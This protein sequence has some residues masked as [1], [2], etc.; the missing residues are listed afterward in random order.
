M[1]KLSLILILA[2]A[3][4]ISARGQV[5]IGT[6]TPENSAMLDVSSNTKGLLIPRMTTTERTAISAPV[7]G[8]IVYDTDID[9]IFI[10][11][12][13]TWTRSLSTSSGW[14]LTGNSG[15]LNSNFIGTSDNSKLK[16]RVNNILSGI[17][18]NIADNTGFGFRVYSSMT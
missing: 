14:A 11:R 3:M 18:D 15:I 2:A 10:Y 12:N 9:D 13:S 5:G 1:K 7:D 16:F 4:F 6:T 17:L 8:L